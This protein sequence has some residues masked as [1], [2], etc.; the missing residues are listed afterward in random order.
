MSIFS[1][2]F[3][4]GGKVAPTNP[5]PPAPPRREHPLKHIAPIPAGKTIARLVLEIHRLKVRNRDLEELSS[6][7]R[8]SNRRLRADNESLAARLRAVNS[9]LS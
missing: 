2:I 7:L 4:R 5:A 6:L 8:E 9:I 3:R 1:R